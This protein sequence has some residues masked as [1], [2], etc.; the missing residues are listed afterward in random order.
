MRIRTI[1]LFAAA[2]FAGALGGSLLGPRPAEA[3]AREIIDL[4]RD[5]TSLLQ[6]QKDMTTQMTQ[7]HTVIKTLLGQASDNVN[8]L[9]VTMGSVQKSVQDVQA[10]SGARLDTMSTQVQGLSDNLEEIKSRLGKLNQQLVDLQSAVQSIDSKV[11]GTAPATTAP[12][13]TATPTG[14]ANNVPNTL[15]SNAASTSAPSADMLYSN[16]L[17]DITSGKYDLARQEFLDYLKFYPNTDLAA[18]AQ[19]YLGEIAYSQK[20]YSDAVAEYDKVLTGYPKSFKLEPAHLKKGLALINLGQKNSGVRELREV[21]RRY[22]GT[23]E[24]RRAR[25]ELKR[26][27]VPVSAA[28]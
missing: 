5:V 19:F 24:D 26:L 14:A 2:M 11:S 16:G 25:E 9:N 17:R 7:D 3:V 27:G 8:R 20:Q 15:P 22:P 23:D 21:I 4:Q 6:G 28:D 1:L 13:A 10:N 12:G 18:N